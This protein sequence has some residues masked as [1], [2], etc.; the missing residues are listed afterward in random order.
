MIGYATRLKLSRNELHG[1]FL[2]LSDVHFFWQKNSFFVKNFKQL[3]FRRG[4]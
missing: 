1:K 2:D 4:W 3:D